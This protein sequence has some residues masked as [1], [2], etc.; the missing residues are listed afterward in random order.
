M[1]TSVTINFR[2]TNTPTSCIVGITRLETYECYSVI[3]DETLEE[4]I[5]SPNNYSAHVT[6]SG[7][8]GHVV[9]GNRN[10]TVMHLATEPPPYIP[11]EAVR[12]RLGQWLVDMGKLSEEHQF[13]CSLIPSIK[14]VKV[15]TPSTLFKTLLPENYGLLTGVPVR[16]TH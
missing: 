14:E 15:I 10:T 12:K 6:V 1:I 4:I 7:K 13:V 3:T 8:N 2:S 9:V 16:V 11:S 5:L